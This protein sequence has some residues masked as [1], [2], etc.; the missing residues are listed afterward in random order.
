MLL[1]ATS[2]WRRS[3]SHS[4]GG[5][6]RLTSDAA[7]NID[8]RS[9]LRCCNCDRSP[10]TTTGQRQQPRGRGHPAAESVSAVP[11]R[12]V[13]STDSLF[14]RLRATRSTAP[15]AES[16]GNDLVDAG[17]RCGTDSAAVDTTR[18]VT[19]RM[20]D[21]IKYANVR[22]SSGCRGLRFHHTVIAVR[23]VVHSCRTWPVP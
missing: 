23:S 5:R 21:R 6:R 1:S 15:L 8:R 3:V 13:K 22:C 11:S 16:V 17:V 9:Q 4:S 12:P 10:Y 2:P 19:D 14:D 18:D 7:T 20:S